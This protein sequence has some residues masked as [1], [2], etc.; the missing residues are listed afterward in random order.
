LKVKIKFGFYYLDL[1]HLFQELIPCKLEQ[2]VDKKINHCINWLG[3]PAYI[4][5]TSMKATCNHPRAEFRALLLM[6]SYL[7]AH[8][9]V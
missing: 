8:Q 1:Q 3:L 7:N 5:L 6:N 2:A 4:P 9:W